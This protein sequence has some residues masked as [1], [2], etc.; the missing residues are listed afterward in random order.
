M[1]IDESPE[2]TAE[3]EVAINTALDSLECKLDNEEKAK[4]AKDLHSYEILVALLSSSNGKAPGPDGIPYELWKTL[5]Q[6]DKNLE[7]ENKEGF[8]VT[9]AMKIVF[10]DIENN[11]LKGGTDFTKAW[12]CLIYKKGDITEIKNYRP[13]SVLNIDYKLFTKALQAKLAVVAPKIIHKNQA[14]FMKN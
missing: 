7:K 1:D 9:K 6:R 4:L 11:G 3:R 10:N 14:S 12:M 8:K 2:K 5:H 13:I